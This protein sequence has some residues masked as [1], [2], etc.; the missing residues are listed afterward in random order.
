MFRYERPQK[1][2]MRQFH[3]IGCEFIGTFEPLAAAE[4]IS[5]ATHLLSELGILDKCKLYLNSLGDAESRDKYR[6]VLIGY[7]KDYSASL[8]RDS[9]RRL[10]LNPLRILDSTAIEDR[11]IIKNWY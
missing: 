1:G 11:E 10:A 3:Q 7:L 5:C 6:S 2:R 4:V 8:S 9:Q